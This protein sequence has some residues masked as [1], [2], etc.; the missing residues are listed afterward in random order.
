M[1]TKT[2]SAPCE[3]QSRKPQFINCQVSVIVRQ[4]SDAL[5]KAT[6]EISLARADRV[7]PMLGISMVDAGKAKDVAA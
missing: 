2:K 7:G 3:L 6:G 4:V 1:F 5:F